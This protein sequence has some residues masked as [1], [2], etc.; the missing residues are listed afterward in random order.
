MNT[1]NMTIS[2]ETIDYGP[3]AFLDTFNP[4]TVFSSIDHFGRYRFENQ[5]QIGVYNL[6]KLGEALGDILGDEK[7]RDEKITAALKIYGDT[8][9]KAYFRYMAHRL[10]F[11]D[12]SES[13][14]ALINEWLDLLMKEELDYNE[15]FLR[16]TYGDERDDW[17]PGFAALYGKIISATGD[18]GEGIRRANNPAIF[19][20]NYLVERAIQEA[21]AG[22]KTFLLHF[23]KL[24][25]EPY[26][27]NEEQMALRG[28]PAIPGYKTF[29]GT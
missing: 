15:S 8:F 19:P 21:E 14:Y 2:G 10:G 11:D 27:H 23:M 17:S 3:C 7:A 9:Q 20:R 13:V 1:D 25:E 24:L 29:C 22:D 12:A 5:G 26:A 6:S 28:A 16:L 4:K 18:A